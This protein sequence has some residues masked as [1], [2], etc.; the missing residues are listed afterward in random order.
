MI[1]FTTVHFGPKIQSQTTLVDYFPEISD[2]P[3]TVRTTFGLTQ[4][5]AFKTGAKMHAV[6][7]DTVDGFSHADCA[8]VRGFCQLL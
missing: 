2:R 3:S 1:F 5:G 8:G 7:N 6:H 4:G